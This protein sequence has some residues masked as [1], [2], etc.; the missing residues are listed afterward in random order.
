MENSA[1][2]QAAA[3]AGRVDI[4]RD[5]H[6]ALRAFMSETL[7]RVSRLDL[8]DAAEVATVLAEVR[9]LMR[10][11]T[12]HLE[13]ENAFVH[14]AIEARRPG[15]SRRTGDDHREHEECIAA[16]LDLVAT[17]ERSAGPARA[18]PL[19]RLQNQLALF[20]G[21]S[22]VHMEIEE[23]ENNAALWA[24]YSDAEL[25]ALHDAIV[26]SLTPEETALVM[27]WLIPAISPAERAGMLAGM[28]EHAPAPVFEGTL[29]I[30]MAHLPAPD[31]HKLCHALT[32]V[33]MAA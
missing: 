9:E 27:R 25:N 18:T 24:A 5:I 15:G 6:R 31:W 12:G 28:R 10:F 33:R 13:H 11:C 7:G 29:A 30:A 8:D 32:P 23:T 16:L 3:A 1:T 21:E 17:V 26:A 2:T 20:V 4:Y 14:A 22:F 19:R